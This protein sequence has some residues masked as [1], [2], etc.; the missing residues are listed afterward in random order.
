MGADG[1]LP[2]KIQVLGQI[3]FLTDLKK[4]NKCQREAILSFSFLHPASVPLTLKGKKMLLMS[5]FLH[6]SVDL[7][8]RPAC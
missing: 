6:S 2:Q 7:S 4:V 1:I 3:W 5:N 8:F